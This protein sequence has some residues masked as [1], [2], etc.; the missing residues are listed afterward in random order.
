MTESEQPESSLP[1]EMVA[2]L[3]LK[4]LGIEAGEGEASYRWSIAFTAMVDSVNLVRKHL[5]KTPE[6]FQA[7]CKLNYIICVS[8][9]NRCGDLL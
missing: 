7:E 8:K 5:G 6:W 9:W 1:V 4:D 2:S 3:R